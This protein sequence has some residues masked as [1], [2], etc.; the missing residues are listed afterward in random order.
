M[1]NNELRLRLLYEQ[2]LGN[3]LYYSNDIWINFYRT[4][5]IT[6]AEINTGTY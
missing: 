5:V 6:G 1:F 2:G 4:I 3:Y